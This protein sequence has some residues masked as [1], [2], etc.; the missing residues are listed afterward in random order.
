MF[1]P[2]ANDFMLTKL[3]LDENLRDKKYMQK[4]WDSGA[5]GYEM[6]HLEVNK[7]SDDDGSEYGG[8]IDL[9]NSDSEEDEDYEDEDMEVLEEEG[10]AP[11]EEEK[12]AGDFNNTKN[13]WEG[14]VSVGG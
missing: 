3:H 12:E 4:H 13:N 10:E 2:N 8:S 5:E 1:L 9:E 7:N 14:Y 11:L 6:G